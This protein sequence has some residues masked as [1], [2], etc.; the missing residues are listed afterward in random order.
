M[1]TPEQR[2]LLMHAAMLRR[3]ALILLEEGYS[4]DL[5]QDTATVRL[6]RIVLELAEVRHHLRQLKKNE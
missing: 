4:T 2:E 5:R 3:E 1:E 6:I